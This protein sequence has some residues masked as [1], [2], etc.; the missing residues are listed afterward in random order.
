[1]DQLITGIQ[2]V[3]I[4]VK[5]IE[6]AKYL[7]RDLFGMN[8]LVFN[9]EADAT[10]MTRYTGGEMHRRKALLSLNMQGGGGFE[11]WQ[12]VSREPSG[13]QLEPQFGDIGILASKIKTTN[14]NIAYT[15]F[16]KES[17]VSVSPILTSSSNQ[18]YFW[19]K[20]I[21]GNNFN[22]VEHKSL[23]K[24]S[25][26]SCGGVTGA[27]IGVTD[28]DKAIHFY[29]NVLGI[30]NIVYDITETENYFDKQNTNRKY[31][32]VLLTKDAATQ[33][34]FSKLLGCVEIELVEAKSHIPSVIYQDRYWGDCGFIHLC[35]DVNDMNGLKQKAAAAGFIFTVDSHDS[36]SMEAAAGR[37]C[38]M[39][40]P[41]KTLIELVETHKVPVFKKMGIYFDLKKRKTN[42]PL[43]DWMVSLLGLSKI[44]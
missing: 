27:V 5:N 40:D 29:K 16:S 33:G 22:V 41:D 25:K 30:Q 20:D 14:I 1:M 11:L 9:D 19:L 18:K 21:Y 26:A 4:G 42:K 12:F 35:F 15:S 37:F 13:P 43:S 34:A 24:K 31:R 23:F 8:V 44:K 3:G 17:S 7:Y 39:E 36:F 10:L 6:E 28:M 32:R 2:Q 38:Y